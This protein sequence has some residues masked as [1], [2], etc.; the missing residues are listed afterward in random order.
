MPSRRE[1]EGDDCFRWVERKVEIN[2][3][4]WWVSDTTVYS[5][6]LGIQEKQFMNLL[7]W[8]INHRASRKRIPPSMVEAIASLSPDIIILTEYVPGPSHM[9][10]MEELSSHGLNHIVM[11]QETPKENHVFIASRN[12]LTRGAIEG[13]PIAPS[14]PSN[15][16][17]VYLESQEMNILG[18]RVP[19]YSKQTP[20]RHKCWDWL[21]A[22]A[23]KIKEQP[24]VI[25]GD[26]NADPSY[27]PSKCGNRIGNLV[28]AG[29][30]LAAPPSGASYLAVANGEGKRLDHAFVSKHFI[31]RN[32]QYV[33]ENN[34][35]I[36]GGKSSDAMSDHAALLVEIERHSSNEALET[37]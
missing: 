14:V 27:P 34:S 15:M 28:T 36:F 22:T 24:F 9:S 3:C 12:A 33:W 1:T 19:D 35:F 32:A 31:V 26:F 11:S 8:N 37:E 29:W 18:L 20:L 30:Q 17:H 16:L 25:L 23:N 13:P 5:A 21:E 7:T 10:F 4:C 6:K 2:S